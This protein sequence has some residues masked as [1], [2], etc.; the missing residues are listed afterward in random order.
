MPT[1]CLIGPL[2]ADS[3]PEGKPSGGSRP[4]LGIGPCN[5][6]FYKSIKSI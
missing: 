6:I 2:R 4:M 1:V 3:F 5:L